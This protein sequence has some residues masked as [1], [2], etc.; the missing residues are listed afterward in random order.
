MA[1]TKTARHKTLATAPPNRWD[2]THLVKDNQVEQRLADLDAQVSKV[3]SLRSTLSSEMPS[4][5]FQSIVQRIEAVVQGTSRLGAYAYLRFSE[6]TKDA[7]ARSLKTHVE[8]RLAAFTNRL[9]FFDLW[10]QGVDKGNA[11][12]LMQD[13]KMSVIIWRRF[14]GTNPTRSRSR[15]KRS[16]TSRM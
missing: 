16:S 13:S 14:A 1:G 5:D 3:E 11:E 8:E 2:L 4:R 15:K 10:W 9:L 12:R 7:K 6:D